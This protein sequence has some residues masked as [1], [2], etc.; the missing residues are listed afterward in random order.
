M[1]DRKPDPLCQYYVYM[2]YV[3]IGLQI[4]GQREGSL[5]IRLQPSFT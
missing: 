4:P 2:F 1:E 5:K 3:L